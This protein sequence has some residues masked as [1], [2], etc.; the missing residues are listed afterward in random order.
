MDDRPSKEGKRVNRHW[1]KGAA[2]PVQKSGKDYGE[3][4]PRGTNKDYSAGRNLRERKGGIFGKG[5]GAS[6][7]KKQKKKRGGGGNFWWGGE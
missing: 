7:G 6:G 4:K 5:T 2:P 1:L 3:C